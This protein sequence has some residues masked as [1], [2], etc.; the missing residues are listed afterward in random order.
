MQC[1]LALKGWTKS[2]HVRADRPN[3]LTA[4]QI[5]TNNIRKN[6]RV[7]NSFKLLL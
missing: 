5:D 1:K 2:N 7:L 6:K 3:L 4:S